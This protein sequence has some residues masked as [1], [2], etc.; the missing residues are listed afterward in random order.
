MSVFNEYARYYDLLYCDKDYAAEA[1]YVHGLIQAQAQGA[2]SILNLGCGSGRHDRCLTELGYTVTGVDLS[3]EMLS[4]ARNA[5]ADN[6]S[7]EYIQGDVRTVRLAHSFDVVISLFHV[8]SYQVSNDDLLAAFATAHSHLKPGGT[9]IFDCWYGPG[10]LTDPPT[11][12]VKELE[13]D[14][15]TV[16]RIAQ[17]VMHPNENV[18]DVNYRVFLRDKASGNAREISETH[19]MRYLFMPEIQLMLSSVGFEPMLFEEWLSS[20]QLG[21]SCW[22]AV[23][24]ARKSF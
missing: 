5:A 2:K 13:D 11:V 9:F 1:E 4:S 10:V 3:E 24:T 6:A 22:N 18:V 19:R 14:V 7:L 8:M 21:F 23:V 20:Y 16:T 17:P 15:I 12:R